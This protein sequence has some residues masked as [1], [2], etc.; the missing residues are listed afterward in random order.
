MKLPANNQ[1]HWAEMGFG[2]IKSEQNT[3]I[4]NHS[5]YQHFQKIFVIRFFK[6]SVDR[7]NFNK[8]SKKYLSYYKRGLII[9]L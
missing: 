1:K 7:V 6:K 9:I 5:K 8:N 4:T 2:C 3:N